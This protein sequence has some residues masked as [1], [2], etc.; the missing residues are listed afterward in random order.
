MEIFGNTHNS[1]E[2]FF[3]LFYLSK[4]SYRSRNFTNLEKMGSFIGFHIIQFPHNQ[5]IF[6][7][8]IEKLFY[9]IFEK[10]KIYIHCGKCEERNERYNNN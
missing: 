8:D 9:K 3:L 4:Y 2:S 5:K 10:E 7:A 1:I 6:F